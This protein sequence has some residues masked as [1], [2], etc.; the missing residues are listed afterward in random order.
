MSSAS[1][2]IESSHPIVG[3][4]WADQDSSKFLILFDRALAVV[5][6]AKSR[7]FPSGHEIRVVHIPSGEVI[8]RKT[9]ESTASFC[10]TL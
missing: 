5:L 3:P 8:Y 9:G 10:D 7:T 4:L 6:A 2:K 1:Y